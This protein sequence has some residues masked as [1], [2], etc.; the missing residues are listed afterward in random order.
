M[1]GDLLSGFAMWAPWSL[2]IKACMALIFGLILQEAMKRMHA[3]AKAF[4]PLEIAAMLL[5]GL[6][7]TGGYYFAEGIM[8]GNW[9]VAALGIP[10]NIAQFL[11]GAGLAAALNTALGKTSLRS[12]M[13]YCT[14]THMPTQ[15][16]MSTHM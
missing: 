7:M 16:H 11:V 5:S 13:A 4:L 10:W 15:T 2:G 6:F 9:A 3:P 8:Y 12:R 14:P 1:L